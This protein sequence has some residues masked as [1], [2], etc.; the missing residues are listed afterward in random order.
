MDAFTRWLQEEQTNVKPRNVLAIVA[1]ETIEAL[2]R[3]GVPP[4][5]EAASL[6]RHYQDDF[7]G[8]ASEGVIASK[9][10]RRA[11]IV[12]LKKTSAAHLGTTSTTDT[13]PGLN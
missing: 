6:M 10:L 11:E 7:G 8:K 3:G 1:R 13:A 2:R 5:L 9:W 12:P 4:V